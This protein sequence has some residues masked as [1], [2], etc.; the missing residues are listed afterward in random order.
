MKYLPA[1]ASLLLALAPVT[2]P[3]QG[4]GNVTGG[5]ESNSVLSADGKFRSNNYLKLDYVKGRFSAGIQAEYYPEPLLG[6]DFNLKGIGLPEKYVA[7]TDRTWSLT[8]GDFYDQFGSGLILRSWEDRDLGWN[9]S[10]GGGRLTLRTSDDVFSMKVLGGYT[11]KYLWYSSEKLA[12]AGLVLRPLDGLSLEGS[13]VVRDYGSGADWSFSLLSEY[14]VGGFVG[15][16]EWVEKHEGNAQSVELVF[17]S[18][19]FSSSLTL[20]R[21]ENMYD[22]MG[23]NYLPSLCMEQSYMLA[24]LNPYTT[25]ASGE[26]GGAADLFFRQGTWR[27]HANGSWIMSLPFALKNFDVMRLAYRDINLEVEKRWN[28]RLKTVAFV[29]IQENSP[30]HGDRKATNAQNVFVLDGVYRSAGKLSY[31]LQAQY[32]YSQELTK[33]WAAAEAEVS[34]TSGWSVHVQDMYNHGSTHEHYYD[35][36]VSWS[37]QGLKIDVSYG[38]QRAGLVCSGGVCRWQ[39]EY[40]GAML[41]LV[42]KI[43]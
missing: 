26:A 9:N 21:L 32:L 5:L 25:F 34:S 43:Q 13:A 15:R 31:R 1:I 38:H 6:Y 28:R 7:W 3:A 20:R 14:A 19:R 42:Y 24:A 36:G 39:P 16:A 29:S 12:G 11:R 22:P 41:R 40:T 18:G 27:F 30:T 35:A 4:W 33:D 10:I 8:A 37:R 2:A 17:A 23:M